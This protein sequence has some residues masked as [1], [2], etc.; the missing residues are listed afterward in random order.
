VNSSPISRREAEVIDA[1]TERD[2]VVFGPREVERFLDVS[3]R[4]AYRIL[5]GMEE[6]ELVHRLARGR[7][8]LAET[9]DALDSYAIASHLE[10]A[11]YVGFWS[12]L[13]FHGMTEQVPRT[14]FVAVTKQKRSL[15]LQGQEVRFVRVTPETFFGYDRFGEAVVSD[16]EKTVLDCL[17]LP[18]YAG[19]IRQV[20]AAITADL[21]VERAIRYAERLDSGAVAARLGY[22]LERK[23]LLDGGDR[24]RE[25]VTSYTKLD[26]S[27]ERTNPVADWKLYDN[28]IR[29]D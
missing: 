29:D 20:D 10:P 17:R 15:R 18:K 27:G 13:H 2:L 24:L 19:G 22:L 26:P 16:P 8:V 23:G 7:Y 9:Y 21:N 14:V 11:S 6:K 28:V 1:I 4:N 12:A 3:A 5:G 25:L